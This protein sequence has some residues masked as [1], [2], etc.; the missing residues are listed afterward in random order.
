[1]SMRTFLAAVF[2]A[3]LA[4]GGYSYRAG[5][6]SAQVPGDWLPFTAGETLRLEVDLPGGVF[7]CKVTQVQ[8]G[9]IGCARDDQQRRSEQWINLRFVKVITPPRER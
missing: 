2:I 1:M 8:N 5:P 3:I 9:F 6:V 7:N 4:L